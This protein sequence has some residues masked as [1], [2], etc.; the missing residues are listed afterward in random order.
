MGIVA[1]LSGLWAQNGEQYPVDLEAAPRPVTEARRAA[2]PIAV[3]GKLDEAV[4]LDAI[5]ITDFVQSQP[6]PG[7]PPTERTVVRVLYDDPRP[8]TL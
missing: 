6:D 3:D 7:M 2:G 4:W 1:P 5:P 8:V